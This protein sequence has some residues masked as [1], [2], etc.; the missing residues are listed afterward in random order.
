MRKFAI[1]LITACML[2]GCAGRVGNTVLGTSQYKIEQQMSDIKNRDQAREFFG[3]PN[4]IFDQDGMEYYEYK[5]ITGHGRYHWLI[6][7]AG[8]I[9]SWWQDTF[10]YRETNLFIGFDGAGNV[11]KWNV[12]QTRGTNG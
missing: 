5:T 12:I 8:W 2:M 1:F 10:V 7:V 4:L 11:E 6:P 3:S 9:M